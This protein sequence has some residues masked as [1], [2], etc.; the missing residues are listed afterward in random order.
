MHAWLAVSVRRY[1]SDFS[2]AICFWLLYQHASP[3]AAVMALPFVDIF[4]EQR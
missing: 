2:G 4:S 3:D 1:S